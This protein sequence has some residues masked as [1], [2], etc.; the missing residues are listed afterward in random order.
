MVEP[1]G[2]LVTMVH[3]PPERDH[4][5]PHG[6]IDTVLFSDG[7]YEGDKGTI[8]AIQ[9]RRDGIAAAVRYWNLRVHSEQV[10][11]TNLAVALEAIARSKKLQGRTCLG[12]DH[13][14]G[15]E[16]WSG[17]QQVDDS[18]GG[19]GILKSRSAEENFRGLVMMLHRWQNKI[20]NDVAFQKLE[21]E[22]PTA[23]KFAD[24]SFWSK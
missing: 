17:V 2:K 22:F 15:C 24:D 5:S 6:K 3:L 20:E 8:R 19:A 4:C 14:T 9:A 11:H 16:Y 23:A 12:F 18:V 13:S 1:G 7:I 10:E 21:S